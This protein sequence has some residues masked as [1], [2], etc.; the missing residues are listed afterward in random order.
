[1]QAK[2]ADAG[3]DSP[4][5]FQFTANVPDRPGT[6]ELREQM[7]SSRD[8][9]TSVEIPGD[10]LSGLTV[11]GPPELGLPGP[12]AV[13]DRIVISELPE[14]DN[15]PEQS[16]AVYEPG[17]AIPIA[18][19][20]FHAATRSRG[21]G[22]VRVFAYESARTIRLITEVRLDQSVTFRLQAQPTH[23]I[24]PS[25]VVP[26]LR[27]LRAMRSP[28]VLVLTLRQGDQSARHEA[29]VPDLAAQ[30]APPEEMIDFIEDLAAIQETLRQP[31][32]LP[33]TVTVGDI[34]RAARLRRLL[35]G[36]VVPW[37]HGSLTV[38]LDPDKVAEFKAQFPT[39]GSGL[40]ISWSD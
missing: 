8:F 6:A 34:K 19:L 22:G 11:T 25:A 16:L 9:G 36:E 35:D 38:T 28:N 10:Y 39:G 3:E 4:I 12:N 1:M 17:A 20:R 14:T 5:T 13:I 26:G 18:S 27:M 37:V 33:Q 24:A 30:D 31:F 29:P 23:P 2:H 7:Q 15:L 40:R 21:A 32:P